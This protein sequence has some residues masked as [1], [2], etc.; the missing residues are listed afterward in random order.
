MKQFMDYFTV[1]FELLSQ[2]LIK[3][4]SEISL[5]T[6]NSV[7]VPPSN[8]AVSSHSIE[9]LEKLFIKLS[10]SLISQ[11]ESLKNISKSSMQ[12]RYLSL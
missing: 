6:I 11:S 2:T 5:K 1:K 4:Q 12:F 3:N 7:V 10:E 8:P 9:K